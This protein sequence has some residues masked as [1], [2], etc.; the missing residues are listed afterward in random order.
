MTDGCFDWR[1][2]S[3][4]LLEGWFFAQ[5]IRGLDKVQVPGVLLETLAPFFLGDLFLEGLNI[6]PVIK[7][8]TMTRHPHVR[9]V[10]MTRRV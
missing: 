6:E 8:M 7:E 3:L 5:K 9:P 4:G 1:E 10:T 2:G